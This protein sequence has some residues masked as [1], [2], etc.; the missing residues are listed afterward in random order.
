VEAELCFWGVRGSLPVGQSQIA[1]H[2]SCVELALSPDTSIF[3]DAGTGIHQAMKKRTLKKLILCLSHFHWDHIQGFPFLEGLY[4]G[5]ME[6]EVISGFRD[7]F[8][9]LSVLFDERFFPVPAEFLKDRIKF[10]FLETGQ[11]YSVSDSLSLQLAPLNH[12]GTSYA[13]RVEGGM[14]SFVYATDSDYDP[15][16]IEADKLLRQAEY[17]VMDSQFLVGDSISKAHYGHSSFKRTLDV[18]AHSRIRNCILFHFDP[19]YSDEEIFLMEA[20]A[21]DYLRSVYG[22]EGPQIILA[23]EGLKLKVPL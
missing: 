17:V 12:P 15:V 2:T 22:A 19:N 21:A 5:E 7:T 23:K 14:S 16:T 3:F 8:E 4:Q 10:K 11:K 1:A 9:R 20:Q 18:A 13:F 6:I